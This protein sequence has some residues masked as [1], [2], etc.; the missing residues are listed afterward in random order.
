VRFCAL[1]SAGGF[2]SLVS[3]SL[4]FVFGYTGTIESYLK[5][6]AKKIGESPR[7]EE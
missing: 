4:A 2:E 1:L 7:I 6:L 5:S 3:F